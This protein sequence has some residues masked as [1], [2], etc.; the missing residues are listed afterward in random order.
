M[1]LNPKDVCL[2]IPPNLKKFKLE[3]F[4]RIGNKIVAQ[5]GSIARHDID[6]I[7]RLPDDVTPI[8]GCQPESTDL[9]DGWRKTGRQ[10][11]YWDRGFFRRWFATDPGNKAATMEASYYRWHLNGFQMR[12]VPKV[13]DDRWR[14]LGLNPKP[15]AKEGRHIVVAAPS[16]PYVKFHRI[17]GWLEETL[18]T[19][20][21]V[22]KRQLVIRHK[23]QVL[24]RPLSQDLG[25]AH[26]L[27]THASI[28]AVEAVL[29]GCP[30]F[31]HPDSAAALVGKTNLKEIETP[32]YPERQPWLNALAHTQFNERELVDGTLWRMI[33]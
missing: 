22:T 33:T 3:L 2:Y 9:I 8:I 25:G 18:D 27:V 15:W 16:R 19:L 26:C 12:S 6:A 20:A 4:E 21:R 7:A 10:W 30:V 17:D 28:A 13:P 11:C 5:G 14:S 1:S 32:I 29:Y 24:T 23:E 31:V